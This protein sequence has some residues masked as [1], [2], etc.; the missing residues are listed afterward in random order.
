MTH[1]P[2]LLIIAPMAASFALPLLDLISPRLRKSALVLSM[3]TQIVLTVT[4]FTQWSRLP[5]E[6]LVGGWAHGI[7]I[8]LYV[9]RLSAVMVGLITLLT[10]MSTVFSFNRIAHNQGKY[11]VLLGLLTAGLTGTVTTGDLF[12]LYV[13][14]E[15]VSIASYS[16]VA[17]ERRVSALEA[18]L[19]YL[20]YGALAGVLML[21]SVVFLYFT[22]GSLNLQVIGTRICNA[23]PRVLA[24]IAGLMLISFSVK[25]GLVP[26]HTWL[27]DAHASAP[28]PIS[29]LLSGV[30][31]KLGGYSLIRVFYLTLG[32]D[33]VARLGVVQILFILGVLTVVVGHLMASSQSES[34][35]LLAYSSV[36]NVGYIAMAL[37]IG[38]HAA[39]ALA[40]VYMVAHGVV[41]A[42]LF[43]TV[44]G[45]THEAGS[46]EIT[47]LKGAFYRWP[48]MAVPLG[49]LVLAVVGI[50]PMVGFAGKW[51]LVEGFV[52]SG[53]VTGLV[54]LIFGSVLSGYYYLRFAALVYTP[55][56]SLDEL[57][58]PQFQAEGQL[59]LAAHLP[60]FVLL[61]AA[62]VLGVIPS[63]VGWDLDTLACWLMG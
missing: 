38:S 30:V 53:D 29:A 35:R 36:A 51:F 55:L 5:L 47:A 40:L 60:V 56:R 33:A 24:V 4:L 57:P 3:S 37:G 22:T 61:T 19:K 54:V 39:T 59:T 11:Y 45:L 44:G 20:M 18:A 63:L 16:L 17:F 42:G 50:P 34:K 32:I 15:I 8:S 14:T 41:K 13:F 9:D 46:R 21:L 1:L 48:L 28:S 12:N 58:N 6:Y 52:R 62:V 31:I 23:P 27:A 25:L 10:C 7:G 49:G 43:L 2:L 26:F